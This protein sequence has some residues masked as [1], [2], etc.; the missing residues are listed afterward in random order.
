M[1]RAVQLADAI[2]DLGDQDGI[3]AGERLIEQDEPAA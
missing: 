3:D 1:P 2:H